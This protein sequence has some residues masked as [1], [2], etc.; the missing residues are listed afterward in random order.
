M[1]DPGSAKVGLKVSQELFEALCEKAEKASRNEGATETEKE[2]PALY[3]R[4]AFGVL[5]SRFC[6]NTVSRWGSYREYTTM[7]YRLYDATRLASL[8]SAN[9]VWY[10]SEFDTKKDIINQ[11]KPEETGPPLYLDELAWLFN[12]LGFSAFSRGNMLDSMVIWQQG[13]EVNALVDGKSDGVYRFQSY[14][15]LGVG[16]IHL[17]NLYH[18]RTYIDKS[19][20]IAY[21]IKDEM[22]RGRV[23]GQKA[24][25]E[26]LRGNLDDADKGF[27]QACKLLKDNPRG[28][29]VFLTHHGELLLKKGDINEAQRKI[30]NSRSLAEGA[31][32][33]DLVAY[34]Q[35]A[36]ANLLRQQ[37]RYTEAQNEYTAALD[38][39]RRFNLRRLET[40]VLTGLSR[41]ACDLHDSE[42]ARQKA[43]EALKVANEASLGLHQ[44]LSLLTLG[45]ALM[46]ANQRELGIAYLRTALLMA[47]EQ[48]YFLRVTE[49]EAELRQVGEK[50]NI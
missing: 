6:A 31:Y 8:A 39:A 43:I 17:G 28:L 37:Q 44:T 23:L 25:L 13:L 21:E 40:A 12:E 4:S 26:Y 30:D 16:F 5:R 15:N 41:W 2:H 38:A 20:H 48:G 19:L 45:K 18:A 27:D 47:K 42:I 32:Y 9:R 35:L 22:L 3:C 34:S 14:F 11:K 10:H 24:L 29:S 50:T 1:V 49:A 46:L 33:P 36:N 7:L